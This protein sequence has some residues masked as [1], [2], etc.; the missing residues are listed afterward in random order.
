MDNLSE[1]VEDLR[2]QASPLIHRTSE[3]ISALAQRGMDAMREG[4]QQ[5]RQK[6]HQAGDATVDFIREE[7]VKAIVIAAAAAAGAALVCCRASWLSC[8]RT[9]GRRLQ[10]VRPNAG[11][12]FLDAQIDATALPVFKADAL[13]LRQILVEH[14]LHLSAELGMEGKP[15]ISLARQYQCHVN[16]ALR[17]GLKGRQQLRIRHEVGIGDAH[18]GLRAVDGREQRDINQ[19]VGLL[20]R[21]ADGTNHLAPREPI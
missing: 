5:V 20:R 17:R 9:R 7:P 2:G 18:T 1:S 3:Q 6:A 21:T 12:K 8:C 13:R 16:A 19:A 11:Q 15:G 14:R 4:G 10:P